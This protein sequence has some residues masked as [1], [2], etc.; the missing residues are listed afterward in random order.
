[1]IIYKLYSV[2]NVISVIDIISLYYTNMK[3]VISYLNFV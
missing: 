1:M 3:S 2:Y